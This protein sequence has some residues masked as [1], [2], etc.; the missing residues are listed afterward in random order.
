M[1]TLPGT[2]TLRFRGPARPDAPKQAP[3]PKKVDATLLKDSFGLSVNLLY[4]SRTR[5]QTALGQDS[6]SVHAIVF[7]CI[8]HHYHRTSRSCHVRHRRRRLR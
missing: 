3:K 1:A 5:A 2:Q 4:T 7:S 6:A 8:P